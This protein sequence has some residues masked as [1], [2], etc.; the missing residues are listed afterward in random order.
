MAALRTFILLSIN[1]IVI[2]PDLQMRADGLNEDHVEDLCESLRNKVVLPRV[3]LRL[4]NGKYFLTDGFHTLEAHKREGKTKISAEVRPGT[5]EDAVQD[6]AAANQHHH[7]L[8]RTN[9]DK[10][11]AAERMLLLFGDWSARKIAD[12][13]GVSQ[14][15]VSKLRGTDDSAYQHSDDST[16]ETEPESQKP[17]PKNQDVQTNPDSAVITVITDQAGKDPPS[18]TQKK[19]A[20]YDAQVFGRAFVALEEQVTILAGQYGQIDAGGQFRL[21]NT[22]AFGLIR[23]L[24]DWKKDFESYAKFLKKDR[25]EKAKLFQE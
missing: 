24:A 13:V 1:E 5:W 10:R 16:P 14:P 17:A 22:Q 25:D 19:Y 21:G 6:A 3:R 2:D 9:A 11:R 4:V 12:H 8:K 18:Q 7:G 20:D 23:K 15:F